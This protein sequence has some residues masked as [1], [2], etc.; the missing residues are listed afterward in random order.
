MANSETDPSHTAEPGVG[1][2]SALG[3]AGEGG[4]P[5]NIDF[6]GHVRKIAAIW[7]FT[8]I[9]HLIAIGMLML[10]A[11]LSE[12][13]GLLRR[14][15]IEGAVVAV[16]SIVALAI[17]K[18]PAMRNW[19]P[20]LQIQ[21]AISYGI[22][23]GAGLIALLWEAS[24]LPVD[25][26]QLACFVAILGAVGVTAMA[27]HAVRAALFGFAAALA[28]MVFA[29]AGPSIGSLL[30]FGCLLCL[31]IATRRLA[32]LDVLEA[33]QQRQ[34]NGRGLLAARLVSEF[35]TQGSGWFWQ[36]DR[37]GNLVYLSEKVAEAV[38]EPGLPP[39]GRAL[40]ALFQIDSA[41]PGTERTLSFHLSSRTGFSDYPVRPVTLGTLDSWWSISGR[42]MVD[43]HG[44][45]EGFIGSGADLTEKRRAEAEITQLALFDGLTGLANRQRMRVSLDKALNQPSGPYRPFTLFLLDLDRF[46]VVNDT[47][48]HQMGDALLKQVAQRLLREVGDTGLVGRL[49]GDEFQIVLPGENDIDRLSEMARSVIASV[50]QPY[51]IDGTSIAIGCSIGI[52]IA[53]Q[54]GRDSETLIRNADLA[55]YAAKADGRGVHRFYRE[56]LLHGAQNRK[57]M[58]D[59]LRN[60]LVQNQF[61]LVYQPVVGT[62]SEQIV[63]FEALLRW[64]H[65][66]RGAISP[67]DFIPVAEDCGLIESIGEWVLRTAC[68]DAAK[69]PRHVRVGVNVSPIQFANPALPAI[70]TN[71]IAKAGIAAGRLE[72]EITEGV[73]LAESALT[74][75]M[76]KSLKGVGVRLALDDFG[77][78]YSSL[79]YL[80]SAPF[81]KIKIDQS[82]VRG[83]VAP[84]SRNAAIIS[85]IVSLANTLSMETTAEGAETRDEIEL[86]RALGC[87][88]IQGFV[89]GKPARADDVVAMLHSG[90]G[91]ATAIGYRVSRSAR[92]AM[93]RSAKLQIGDASGE[94]RIR[95]MSSTGAMIDGISFG[96][97]VGNIDL[98]IE[99]LEGQMFPAKLRWAQDGKAGIEFTEAFNMERLSAPADARNMR[100]VG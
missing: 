30:G 51:F 72:L 4:A 2:W 1:I 50:S 66:T 92:T 47:L 98:I 56:E 24:Q 95:N 6:A 38:T 60:A 32:L 77:T 52:A 99:L 17:L 18:L 49:G 85:A 80:K 96:A 25:R 28:V 63:G 29:L 37:G 79:G 33:R 70:V 90:Q 93:I 20:R 75:Q 87:S 89:Y 9:T 40:T 64:E 41:A 76:F 26:I 100:K 94:V 23:L 91:S 44:E 36:T 8:F 14:I 58:E 10:G 35:E 81:D 34:A 71:A 22:A 39:L 78:G 65:P 16:A 53:P 83:A 67:A 86:I 88:H 61:H 48:G 57:Q 7:P 21:V 45:F 11:V 69:W 59:D 46:K 73:F 97:S 54:D 82:F 3:L 74:D 15:S 31:G 55:L 27:L 68:L 42:P 12:Q 43:A 84:G 62:Q 5:T 13:I 19:P